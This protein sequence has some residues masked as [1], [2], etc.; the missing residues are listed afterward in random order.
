MRMSQLRHKSL[1]HRIEVHQSKLSGS[2]NESNNSDSSARF[3][4]VRA[5]ISR[6]SSLL[7]QWVPLSKFLVLTAISDESGDLIASSPSSIIGSLA[8]YWKPVF[9]GSSSLVDDSAINSVLTDLSD[10]SWD[11]SKFSLPG[12]G[13]F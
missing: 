5:K 1:S 9:D 11:W 2:Q 6:L 12:P 7:R 10:H 3:T 4:K 13:Q 8:S